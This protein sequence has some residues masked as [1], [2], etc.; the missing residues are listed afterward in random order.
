MACTKPR[1]L[2]LRSGPPGS[3]NC[4]YHPLLACT[5]WWAQ[6]IVVAIE[7]H[8]RHRPP[9]PYHFAQCSE[10]IVGPLYIDSGNSIGAKAQWYE[11]L[12]P[13]LASIPSFVASVMS[14]DRLVSLK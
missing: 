12:S 9:D 13:S 3:L 4:H 2:T 10:V 6:G 11:K 5:T 14:Q 1:P 8:V 7:H